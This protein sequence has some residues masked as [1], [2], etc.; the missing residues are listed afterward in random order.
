MEPKQNNVLELE[1]EVE[2]LEQKIAPG[3]TSF[4]Y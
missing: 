3:D 4:P 2:E 1:I